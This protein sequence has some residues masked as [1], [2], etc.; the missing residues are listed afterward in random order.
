MPETSAIEHLKIAKRLHFQ[1]NTS[2]AIREYEAVLEIDPDNGDAI[3]G[4]RSLGVEPTVSDDREEGVVSHAGGLKTNFF[5]NQAASST[6]GGAQA[7]VFKVIIIGLGIATVYGL[8]V[9]GTYL[10]NY[11]NIEAAKNVDVHFEKP[12]MKENV[13]LVNVQI[14]NLNPAPIKHIKISYR[15]ADPQDTTLKEGFVE[16]PGQVPAGDRRTF[17]ET[18][19]GELKGVPSK[20]TPRLEALIYGPK[21]KL[22]DQ[23]IDEFMKAASV[24]DKEALNDYKDLVEHL[25]D[26]APAHVGLGRSYAAQGKFDDAL[27][28][29][30]RALEIDP[31]NANAHYYSAVALYYQGDK[32]GARK[33]IDQAATLAPDDPEIAWNQKYLL[34]VKDTKKPTDADKKKEK[35]GVGESKDDKSDKKKK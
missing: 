24:K 29:Y 9:L 13:A 1:G 33:E 26:F 16:L 27:K 5:S 10:M 3:A 6:T 35:E 21:P 31:L 18:S 34:A 20:L 15:I 25:D 28:E 32:E 14:I 30:K 4:L 7:Q 17:S 22:K 11:D 23:Q 8:Y 12:S 2:D 19:L